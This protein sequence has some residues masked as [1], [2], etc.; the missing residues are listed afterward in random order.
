[1]HLLFFTVAHEFRVRGEETAN[2]NGAHRLDK[3]II[4]LEQREMRAS[5]LNFKKQH[6]ASYVE[7]YPTCTETDPSCSIF[8]TTAGYFRPFCHKAMT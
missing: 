5:L 6:W 1:M 8:W 2:I 7:K 3:A 4:E